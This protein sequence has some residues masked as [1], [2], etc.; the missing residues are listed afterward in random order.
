MKSKAALISCLLASFVLAISAA[1][2][3]GA[4]PAAADTLKGTIKIFDWQ[5]FGGQYAKVGK[6]VVQQYMK[7]HPGATIK[8]VSTWN[9]D[10]TIYEETNLAAGTAED[11]VAPSYT[12]QVWNDLPKNYW[13]DLTPYLQEPNEY[14]PGNKHWIDIYDPVINGQNA[15]LGKYYVISWQVQDAAFF[16]NKDIFAKLG[17]KVPTTWAE[18][19]ADAEKVKKA[20]LVPFMYFLGDTYPIAENGSIMSLFE[21]QVMAKTFQK[22]DMNH[23]G[24][25]DIRELVYGVKHKI[26][27]PMN[28]DY[29]EAWKLY[30][31]WSQYW[32]PNAI[33]KKGPYIS[34][35]PW[36]TA[37]PE[38]F[39]GQ[40][41]MMF[42][43]QGFA[44]TL[45]S[46]KL[47][48]KWGV[49]SFPQITG[50][51]SSFAT[52]GKKGV[53]IWGAW[54][55]I[56]WGVPVTTQKRGNL[57]LAI[58]FLKWV[59]APKNQIAVDH[60][61]GLLPTVKDYT[62]AND[63]EKLFVSQYKH[64]TMQFAAEATFGPEWLTDRIRVQQQ[65]I[66][67]SETL[68]QAMADMQ[69]YTDAAADRMIKQFKFKV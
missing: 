29:Q 32:E 4:A 61:Q 20:G 46:V 1:G 6:S 21:S 10:P 35:L 8:P 40:V 41:A 16:Y 30:K 45:H 55:A 33:G 49:F 43:A 50:A 12:Q 44:Q 54:N 3:A 22:L 60:E 26:Y 25:V 66:I 9:G 69:R 64:P 19:L 37:T 34:G 18:M 53:G 67:G 17:L 62:P 13:L 28:K 38:W 65:Y 56:A 47:P 52:P 23:D 5:A 36:A 14:V 24:K 31:A 51:T 58:D 2:A 42:A 39:K 48:F 57:P 15:F 11:I 27:S 68:D 63:F 59:T 7:M